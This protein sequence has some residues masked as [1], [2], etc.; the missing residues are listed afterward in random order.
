LPVV[1]L[2]TADGLVAVAIVVPP[3]V[4]VGVAVVRSDEV[5]GDGERTVLA[6][7]GRV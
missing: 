5:I 4:V 3:V 6:M 7:G 1:V 2:V